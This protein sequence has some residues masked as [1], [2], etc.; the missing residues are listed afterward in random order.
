LAVVFFAL[1][2]CRSAALS[3]D[4]NDVALAERIATNYLAEQKAVLAD[5]RAEQLPTDPHHEAYRATGWS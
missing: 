4:S 3:D 2:M 5:S 1:T